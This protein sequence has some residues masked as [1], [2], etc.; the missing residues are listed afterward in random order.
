[1][2]TNQF[3]GGNSWPCI[4]LGQ[5]LTVRRD[6]RWRTFAHGIPPTAI[7]CLFVFLCFS[8]VQGQLPIP[9]FVTDP[10]RLTAGS[11]QK[12]SKW[13]QVF[14]FGVLGASMESPGGG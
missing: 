1:M 6:G 4:D 10:L 8:G 3:W 9:F 12:A 13:N 14:H 11:F 5:P 2:S 7:T